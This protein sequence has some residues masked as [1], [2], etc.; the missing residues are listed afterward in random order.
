VAD[1]TAIFSESTKVSPTPSTY[2]FSLIINLSTSQFLVIQIFSKMKLFIALAAASLGLVSGQSIASLYSSIPPAPVPTLPPLSQSGAPG[3]VANI[4]SCWAPCVGGAI[5]E[6]CPSDDSWDC[7]CNAYFNPEAPDF[8]ELATYDSVCE[9][10][11]ANVGASD[12]SEQGL[13][14]IRPVPESHLAG[15]LNSRLIRLGV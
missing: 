6:I 7:A 13:Y 15:L 9:K 10:C 4:P 1:V 2:S 3:L 8:A 12:G 5:K 14:S 11:P